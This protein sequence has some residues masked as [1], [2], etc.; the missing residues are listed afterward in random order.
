MVFGYGAKARCQH[1]LHVKTRIG[2]QNNF[3]IVITQLT[4]TESAVVTGDAVLT[5]GHVR[6]LMLRSRRGRLARDRVPNC[7]CTALAHLMGKGDVTADVRR[8]HLEATIE[9]ATGGTV[10]IA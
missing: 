8:R 9:A 1:V 7:L 5:A 2:R 4:I 6:G 3:L 10:V